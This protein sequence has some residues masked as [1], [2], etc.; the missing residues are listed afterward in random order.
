MKKSGI[1]LLF[2][3][4]LLGFSCSTHSPVFERYNKFANNTWNRFDQV[5][6]NVPFEKTEADYD[7]Y[8][9]I[10]PVKDFDYFVLPV[11]IIMKTPSGE[12]RMKDVTVHLKENNKFIGEVEGQPVVIKTLLWKAL[13]IS[14]KGNCRIS[15]ENMIPKIQTGG[16]AEIGIVVKKTE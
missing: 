16:I 12:E 11:Y 10:K 2:L 8:L 5:V 15:I 13:R 9:V 14:D 7:I 3:S 6:F 4:M 1:I